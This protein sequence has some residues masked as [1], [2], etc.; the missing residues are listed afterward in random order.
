MMMELE[1][2]D[3]FGDRQRCCF[4]FLPKSRQRKPGSDGKGHTRSMG[5]MDKELLVVRGCLDCFS[6]TG[7]MGDSAGG[8]GVSHPCTISL[9]Q[10]GV[11]VCILQCS[12]MLH[13]AGTALCI[14]LRTVPTLPYIATMYSTIPTPNVRDPAYGAE[15]YLAQHH[16]WGNYPYVNTLRGPS[17]FI[18]RHQHPGD[19]GITGTLE[20]WNTKP[21]S[22]PHPP[23]LTRLLLEGSRVP[24][25]GESS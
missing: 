21:S 12:C 11:G 17:T 15:L 20:H 16:I 10:A 22:L 6:D 19:T 2:R 13:P 5:W 7:G 25:S 24:Y 8:R 23:P 9:A 1:E 18:P 3:K 14:A 4:G